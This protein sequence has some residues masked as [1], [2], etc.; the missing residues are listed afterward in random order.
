MCLDLFLYRE[1]VYVGWV[2]PN[3]K[4]PK[5][6]TS[7]WG[8]PTEP[9]ILTPPSINLKHP[10]TKSI[11]SVPTKLFMF[12]QPKLCWCCRNFFSSLTLKPCLASRTLSGLFFKLSSLSKQLFGSSVA[13]LVKNGKADDPEHFCC[14]VWETTSL[15]VYLSRKKWPCWTTEMNNLTL[16]KFW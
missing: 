14:D 2:S 11:F 7:S 13:N 8:S 15:L 16:S 9:E 12:L 3:P 5:L 1:D 4:E 6:L 10:S